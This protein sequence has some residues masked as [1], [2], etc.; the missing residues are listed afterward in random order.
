[1]PS[2]GIQSY[3]PNQLVKDAAELL[4]E[5][6]LA[7]NIVSGSYG[8]AITGASQLLRALGILPGVDSVEYFKNYG[9]RVWGE[10]QDATPEL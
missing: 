5:R 10:S 2:T 6:G 4:R 9:D 7:A 3:D 8:E 1:M